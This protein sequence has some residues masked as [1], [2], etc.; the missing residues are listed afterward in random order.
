MRIKSGVICL[1]IK[2]GI[3]NQLFEYAFAKSLSFDLNYKLIIDT[4]TGFARD[5]Y[6]RNCKTSYFVKK[7]NE[8]TVTKKILF[9]FTRKFP[10]ISK[11]LFSSVLLLEKNHRYLEIIDTAKLKESK[12][13]F[14]EGY[15]QSFQY[16]QHNWNILFETI[17]FNINSNENIIK[18]LN[19]INENQSVSIH[20]RRIDYEPKLDIVYYKEAVNY[21]LNMSL[22]YKFYIFSDD[23]DWCKR[24]FNFIEDKFFISDLDGD[25]VVE[26][27]L[28]SKCKN[29]IIANSSFSWWA[30]WLSTYENKIVICPKK[31]SYSFEG[32]DNMNSLIPEDWI[33]IEN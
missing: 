24:M 30:A 5:S 3:G 33:Q 11:I 23:I 32:L 22:N 20:V 2:G 1:R 19:E 14:V 17:Y 7:Y 10:K 26:L 8:A 18:L 29:N 28:M 13:I 12:T 21:F 31:W 6:K 4:T 25:E 9:F 15:F 27:Y 16:F